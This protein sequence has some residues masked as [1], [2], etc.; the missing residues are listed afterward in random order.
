MTVAI[1]ANCAVL[2]AYH[3]NASLVTP[4]F[5]RGLPVVATDGALRANE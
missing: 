2:L 3:S 4:W 5:A 1:V